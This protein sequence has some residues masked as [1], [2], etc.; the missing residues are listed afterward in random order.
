[1]QRWGGSSIPPH[2]TSNCWRTQA[3]GSYEVNFHLSIMTR[4]ID[5]PT[6]TCAFAVLGGCLK[7]MW[8]ICEGWRGDLTGFYITLPRKGGESLLYFFMSL[9]FRRDWSYHSSQGK[10]WKIN[11]AVIN[12]ALV[13]SG[14]NSSVI[15]YFCHTTRC[16]VVAY[17][18][19]W[20]ERKLQR[21]M[22]GVALRVTGMPLKTAVAWDILQVKLNTV[23]GVPCQ[24]GQWTF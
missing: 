21:W 9:P 23:D 22:L 16:C 17:Y 7:L 15:S 3:G 18:L 6:W 20:K 14:T 24:P 1:M 8:R 13:A 19:Q 4:P 5:D 11:L 10:A 2:S 12:L